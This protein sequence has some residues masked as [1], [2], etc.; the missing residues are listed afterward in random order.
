ML[1]IQHA[2]TQYKPALWSI[3]EWIR[4]DADIAGDVN[5]AEPDVQTAPGHAEA[6]VR[7]L[8][9]QHGLPMAVVGWNFIVHGDMHAHHGKGHLISLNSFRVVSG[10]IVFSVG[11]SAARERIP[12][13]WL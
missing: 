3:H 6:D 11:V 5:L 1:R 4:I 8:R 12:V 13:I 9:C 2:A 7:V 10:R